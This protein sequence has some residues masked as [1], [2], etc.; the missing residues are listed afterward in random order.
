MTEDSSLA[1][2]GY[3]GIL[4]ITIEMPLDWNSRYCY[5]FSYCI[6][7]LLNNWY[8]LK[9]CEHNKKEKTEYCYCLSWENFGQEILNSFWQQKLNEK[10]IMLLN[11]FKISH[12]RF[13]L[14]AIKFDFSVTYYRVLKVLKAGCWF[15]ICQSYFASF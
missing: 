5:F 4:K 14:S 2:C 15:I 3:K 13:L 1:V 9:I 8:I 11:A 6:V 7:C 12:S 10:G